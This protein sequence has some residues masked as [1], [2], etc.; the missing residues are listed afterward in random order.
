MVEVSL[1]C[2]VVGEETPFPVDIDAEKK[3]GHLKDMIQEKIDYDGLAKNLE[4]YQVDGL[5]QIGK[6]RFHFQGTVIDDMPAK[7]LVDFDGS[8]T[9]MV[10]TF[11]LSSYP[12]LNDSPSGRIHV[13][14]VVP[15]GAGV[16]EISGT[17]QMVKKVDEMHAQIVQANP[18][19]YVHSQVNTENGKE[20]LQDLNIEVEP[21]DTMPF[22]CEDHT[23]PVEAFTWE[24]VRNVSGKNIALFE[25]QQRSEYRKYIEDNI[26]DVL[27]EKGLC[28]IGVEKSQNILSTRVPGHDIKLSGRTD[29]L[30]LGNIVKKSPSDVQYLPKVKMLIEVK[31][32]IGISSDYQALSEL[33]ALDLIVKEVPVAALLTDLND[34]WRFFWFSGSGTR[35]TIQKLTIVEPGK[36]FQIIRMLLAQPSDAELHLPCLEQPSKRRKLAKM[37]PHITEGGGEGSISANLQRYYDISS[38]MG[39]DL[40]MARQVA[41][42]ITR[43]IPSFGMYT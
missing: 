1:N 27:A 7:L 29:L 11:S 43:S 12:G 42:Q 22:V 19:K 5:T 4:L 15:E 17:A 35:A 20:L 24:N 9:E 23:T 37:L 36:A 25:E 8:T 14:V 39:P 18:K 33:I 2:L 38:M 21:L 28:V 31:R 30:I 3:V 40:D 10:E 32:A 13:L 26:G 16:S 6:T 34:N 41:R